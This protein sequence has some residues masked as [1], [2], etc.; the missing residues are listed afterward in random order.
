MWSNRVELLKEICGLKEKCV[1]ELERGESLYRQKGRLTFVT[2]GDKACQFCSHY[3]NQWNRFDCGTAICK[4]NGRWVKK[5][6]MSMR[7]NFTGNAWQKYA[8]R[9]QILRDICTRFGPY[10]HFTKCS[11]IINVI[12]HIIFKSLQVTQL[13]LNL[14]KMNGVKENNLVL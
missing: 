12:S 10:L 4:M 7:A 1:K 2:W 11:W 8:K 13:L 9:V 6:V 5:G 3:S 14:T